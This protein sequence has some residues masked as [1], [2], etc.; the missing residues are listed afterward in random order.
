MIPRGLLE[1][2]APVLVNVA[3]A[4]VTED[5]GV[6]VRSADVN[7]FI[8]AELGRKW[9]RVGQGAIPGTA[10]RHARMRLFNPG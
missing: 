2:G 8:V 6:V 7:G 5:E 10:R 9:Q 1:A 3:F 4:A